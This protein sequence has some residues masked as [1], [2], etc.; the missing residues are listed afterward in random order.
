MIAHGDSMRIRFAQ[1]VRSSQRSRLLRAVLAALAVL[2]VVLAAVALWLRGEDRAAR[3]FERAAA[4]LRAGIT[5]G[6][7]FARLPRPSGEAGALPGAD[8]TVDVLVPYAT[9]RRWF[10]VWYRVAPPR[11]SPDLAPVEAV[12]VY[13]VQ[14]RFGMW[15]RRRDEHIRVSVHKALIHGSHPDVKLL[16]AAPRPVAASTGRQ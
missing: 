13:E 14:A 2:L 6:E 16:H 1:S 3:E 11:Q 12:R 5:V 15:G 7:L 4:G 10:C 9:A 8:G